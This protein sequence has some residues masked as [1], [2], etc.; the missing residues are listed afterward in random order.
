MADNQTTTTG[1]TPPGDGTVT[2]VTPNPDGATPNGQQNSNQNTQQPNNANLAAILA[3]LP[4]EV[5]DLI[6]NNQKR[7]TELNHESEDRRKKLKAIEDTQ[8]EAEKT[9]LANEKKWEE[10]AETYRKEAE[11][12]KTERAKLEQE[13]LVASIVAKHGLKPNLAKFLT[14]TTEAELDA[15]AAELAKEVKAPT[16]ANT[17]GGSGSG[18][19][20]QSGAGGNNNQQAVQGQQGQQQQNR[21]Y[22]FQQPGDIAW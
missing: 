12:E 2:G 16:P 11:K 18:S 15:Q 13:K 4:K 3:T 1:V 14:G 22:V 6:A 20:R 17:E 19:N 10:L 5:Q 9:R 21:T 8:S 7:I